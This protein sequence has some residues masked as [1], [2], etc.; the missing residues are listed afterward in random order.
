[1]TIKVTEPGL[2]TTIQDLGRKGF[3]QYGMVV[4][5]VMD[6]VAAR[7]ANIMV[8]NP[9]GEAVLEITVIGPSLIFEEDYLI[10]ICGADL[11]ANVDN[12]PVPLWRPMLVRKGSH[13][14]FG[15]PKNC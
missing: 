2:L 11:S 1:M 9:E 4:G 10:S 14:T 7:L 6:E 15:R 5:G 8:G 12:V 3:Q 13:L